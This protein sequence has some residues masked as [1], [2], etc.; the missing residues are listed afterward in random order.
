MFDF[1][2]YLQSSKENGNY[3]HGCKTSKLRFQHVEKKCFFNSKRLNYVIY[4]NKTL[5]THKD[6]V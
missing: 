6:S 3:L 1:D 4:L 2:A 5:P